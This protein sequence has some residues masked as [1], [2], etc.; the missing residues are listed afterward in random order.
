MR[1]DF[2][3]GKYTEGRCDG[4]MIDQKLKQSKTYVNGSKQYLQ[5][6]GKEVNKFSSE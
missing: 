4:N 2:Y 5:K 3:W 6:E 1:W